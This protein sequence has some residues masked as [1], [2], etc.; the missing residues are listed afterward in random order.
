MCI[1][2]KKGSGRGHSVQSTVLSWVYTEIRKENLLIWG[3]RGLDAKLEGEQN[4]DCCEAC[5]QALF[6]TKNLNTK[7]LKPKSC[8][9]PSSLLQLKTV[10]VS[11]GFDFFWSKLKLPDTIKDS[12]LKIKVENLLSQLS[13]FPAGEFRS[14]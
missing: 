7:N 14:C 9:L 8:A 13:H 6:K 4:L 12:S 1:K 11:K 10:L 3:L 5:V 2:I